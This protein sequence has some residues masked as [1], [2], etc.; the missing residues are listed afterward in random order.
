MLAIGAKAHALKRNENMLGRRG[1][2]VGVSSTNC[3]EF[4]EMHVRDSWKAFCFDVNVATFSEENEAILVEI[5]LSFRLI[6][7]F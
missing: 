3:H 5:P 2:Y 4:A 1:S 7:E 6:N